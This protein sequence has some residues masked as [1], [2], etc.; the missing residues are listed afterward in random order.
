MI[1]GI[2][3]MEQDF[4]PEFNDSIVKGVTDE[5]RNLLASDPMYRLQH[6]HEDKTRALTAKERLEN[7]IE[8]QESHSRKDYDLNSALRSRNREKRKRDAVLAEEGKLRGLPIPLLEEFEG[9]RNVARSIKF[10]PKAGD[11][12]SLS[13]RSKM[14]D[15]ANQPIF[16]F[17]KPTI[18]GLTGKSTARVSAISTEVLKHQRLQKAAVK[19]ATLCLDATKLKMKDNSA[20]DSQPPILRKITNNLKCNSIVGKAKG[21]KRFPA[22][23]PIVNGEALEIL[24]CSYGD[25]EDD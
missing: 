17:D 3:K 22:E 10:R 15:L 21:T 9:D 20:A 19:Q 13:E 6:E 5:E 4:E 11:K 2:R 8:L 7:L 14:V 25:V 18:V 24:S 16:N 1:T 23:I 12:F